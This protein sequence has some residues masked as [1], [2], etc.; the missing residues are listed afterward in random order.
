MALTKRWLRANVCFLHDAETGPI[1]RLVAE[2]RIARTVEPELDRGLGIPV[3][4]LL[5]SDRGDRF[6]VRSSGRDTGEVLVVQRRKFDRRKG[7]EAWAGRKTKSIDGFEF[8]LT[9]EF[10]A[11]PM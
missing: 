5:R 9:S 2:V 6:E 11:N 7:G 3:D 10:D 1:A 4:D 8:L